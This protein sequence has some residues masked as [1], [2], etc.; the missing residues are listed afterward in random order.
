[1]PELSTQVGHRLPYTAQRGKSSRLLA[2][3]IRTNL[4]SRH[5]QSGRN[6]VIR[7]FWRKEISLQ[8]CGRNCEASPYTQKVPH[9]LKWSGSAPAQQEL[10]ASTR[11]IA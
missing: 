10:H 8:K 4:K 9:V 11:C 5:V 6:I 1:M 3:A 2:Q 7:S